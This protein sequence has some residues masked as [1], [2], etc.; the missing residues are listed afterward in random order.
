MTA[1]ADLIRDQR[2]AFAAPGSS[3]DRLVRLLVRVLPAGVGAVV[4]V[5]ILAPFT[6]RGEISFLLDRNK[7]AVTSERLRV[8]KAM[9]RGADNQG[10]PFSLTAGAAVQRSAKDPTVEMND[11]VARIQ[12]AD[13]PAEISAPVGLYN[14]PEERVGVIG[15]LNFRAADGY[16]MSASNV[17]VDLKSRRVEGSG[18]VSGSIPAGTFSANRIVADLAGRTVALDGRARLRMQPGKLRMP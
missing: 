1:K 5:M 10:R 15:P 6:P 12:L 3:H 4:A 9:Y 7:V 8:D 14:I 18:G 2:R 13:G 17:T 16:S 11:L